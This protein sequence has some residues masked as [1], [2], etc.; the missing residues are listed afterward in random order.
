VNIFAT[1]FQTRGE[2][3]VR[4]GQV[5]FCGGLAV[6]ALAQISP[7]P[8]APRFPR[9][10]YL[11]HRPGLPFYNLTNNPRLLARLDLVFFPPAP[12]PLGTVLAP[13]DPGELR[14]GAP[15]ELAAFVNEPFYAP[16]SAHL[17]SPNPHDWLVDRQKQQLE[18]YR[19]SKASLQTELL[20]RLYTLKDVD[21]A[22]RLQ[23]LEAFAREQTP[24]LVEL[25]KRAEQ[26][27]KDLIGGGNDGN[28]GG[29][30]TSDSPGLSVDELRAAQA[31]VL[32][33]AVF[34]GSGLAPAQRRLLREIVIE[35]EEGTPRETPPGQDGRWLFFSPETARVQLPPALP[36]ELVAKVNAYEST[37]SAL[38][39]ELRT[40]LT[41][42]GRS[43]V[44]GNQAQEL[45]ALAERQE[46]RL[47]SLEALAEDIRHRLQGLTTDP[48]HA[49]RL[50]SLSPEL[51]ERIAAY[52]KAKLDLQKA[53][54]AK[55]QEITSREAAADSAAVQD[56]VQQAIAVFTRENSPRYDALEKAKEGIRGDLAHVAAAHPNGAG[57]D[58]SADR[59]LKNFTDSLQQHERWRLYYEYRIAV[60]EPGLSPEQR[61]LLFANA[62]EKLVLPLPGG[63][64]QPH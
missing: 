34:Y 12:P 53:L 19:A 41:E 23:A 3:A 11:D 47:A 38:K 42:S 15:A 31:T 10:P 9:P 16:L 60:F 30:G 33:T 56:K 13:T 14:L 28:V 49:L 25:E 50:P 55:V 27:R 46:P 64:P 29:P 37:K 17:A 20:A 21:T 8:A 54:L 57:N 4:L 48:L 5:A 39:N 35:I 63:A 6:S 1:F 18:S 61:R 59:L 40:A 58:Q 52:R 7:N 24:R 26:L 43:Y 51:E 36:A 22:S 32:R 45:A 62:I 44:I 2:L